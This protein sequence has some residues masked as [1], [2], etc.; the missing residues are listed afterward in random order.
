MFPRVELERLFVQGTA[1]RI[2]WDEEAT[3]LRELAK[4]VSYAGKAGNTNLPPLTSSREVGYGSR[5]QRNG[6]WSSRKAGRKAEIRRVRNDE[7]DA[8]VDFAFCLPKT[9]V[10]QQQMVR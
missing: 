8:V 10:I 3:E 2:H 1:G 9:A 5:A 7:G 4:D 6:H